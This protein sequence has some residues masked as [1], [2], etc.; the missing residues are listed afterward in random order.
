MGLAWK[1]SGVKNP[2]AMQETTV[3][4]LVW[5]DSLE[6]GQ[7][8]HCSILEPPWWLSWKTICLPCGQPG[9]HPWGWEDLPPSEEGMATHSS[10]LS[11]RIPMDG[12]AW[13][14]TVHGVA[15]SQTRLSGQ[16]HT[17]TKGDT[18]RPRLD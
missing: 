2:P 7:A 13:Q 5:E 6:K 9:F 10:T 4:F 3:Q 15:E 14:A 16:A 17:Y 8:I 12:G 1:L 11:C 18:Q